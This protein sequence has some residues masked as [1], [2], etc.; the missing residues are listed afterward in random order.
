MLQPALLVAPTN[1]P[2]GGPVTFRLGGDCLDRF[3]R[4]NS[5]DDAGVLDLEPGQP[6]VVGHCLQDG[7]ICVSDCQG[8]RF[9]S[10]HGITSNAR[11][12]GYLQRTRL[13]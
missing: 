12:R 4:S 3:T 5:Q 2:D 10:T 11:A 9:A 7:Q 6:S 1:A 13:P 8:A